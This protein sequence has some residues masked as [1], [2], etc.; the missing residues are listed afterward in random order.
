[1]MKEFCILFLTFIIYAFFGWCCEC[2]Y[3]S[4]PAKKLIN[5]GFLTGPICPV[6]GFGAVIVFQAL[7]PL[8]SNIFL[9]FFGGLL[10]TSTLEYITSFLLEKLFHL[11]W[12]D[13]SKRKFNLHGRVCLRNSLLF[14]ILCVFAVHVIDPWVSGLVLSLSVEMLSFLSGSILTMLIID[15]YVPCVPFSHST[16]VCSKLPCCA[17]NSSTGQKPRL[18]S[19]KLHW[20]PALSNSGKNGCAHG[21]KQ[22]TP[23]TTC[24][25]WKK[26][27][28][29]QPDA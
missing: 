9:T 10:L 29:L 20:K 16:G 23:N 6:Y 17:K 15:C 11:S 26:T 22:N 27:I 19:S 14:G 1:M 18:H 8:G 13:Y 3:C 4:I 2:I 28:S 25:S 24:I 5:R 7:R 12:W 21:L